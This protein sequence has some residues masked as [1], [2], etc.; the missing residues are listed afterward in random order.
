MPHWPFRLCGMFFAALP[1]LFLL[2]AAYAAECIEC[3]GI[4][5]VW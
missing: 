2:Y 3:T 5:D 4:P 1:K